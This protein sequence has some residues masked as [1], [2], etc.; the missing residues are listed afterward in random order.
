MMS[1]EYDS[2]HSRALFRFLI[3]AAENAK[4]SKRNF[5]MHDR[6]AARAVAFQL[7]LPTHDVQRVAKIARLERWGRS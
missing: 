1:T 4:A 2:P 6:D 5:P 7:S 3:G